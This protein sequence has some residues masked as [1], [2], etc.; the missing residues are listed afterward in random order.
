MRERV[1]VNLRDPI[2]RSEVVVSIVARRGRFPELRVESRDE[3]EAN[4]AAA[5]ITPTKARELAQALL[6][7]ADEVEESEREGVWR[8]VEIERD[9]EADRETSAQPILR[10]MGSR[11][12]ST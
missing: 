11:G 9:Q 7:W 3:V 6:V 5:R 10:R 8:D 4:Q 1:L 2:E 12:E